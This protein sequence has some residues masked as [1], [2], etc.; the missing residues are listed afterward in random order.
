MNQIKEMGRILLAE[1]LAQVAHFGQKRKWTHSPEP[2]IGHLK[3]VAERVYTVPEA[4]PDMV[5]AAYCHDILEDTDE[6]GSDT[7]GEIFGQ[8]VRS[9]VDDLTDPSTGSSALRA[10]R[11]KQDRDHMAQCC[12][13]VKVIK[14]ADR[15]DNFKQMVEC[16]DLVPS[17]FMDLYTVETRLLLREALKGVD[18][19]ME[20]ELRALLTE[21]A[22]LIRNRNK[23]K[24]K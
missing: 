12:Y 20:K 22:R 6:I 10:E 13:A 11:K 7:L 15:L 2:Y 23:R 8:T 9:Y 21:T 4:T 5:I 17:R 3:R 18:R 24:K 19:K 1:S 14:L 16:F